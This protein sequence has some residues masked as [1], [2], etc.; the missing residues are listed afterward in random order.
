[1]LPNSPPLQ[2]QFLELKTGK[3]GF[4]IYWTCRSKSCPEN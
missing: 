2:E 1:M 4:K 3:I